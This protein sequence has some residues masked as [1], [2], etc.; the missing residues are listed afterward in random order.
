MLLYQSHSRRRLSNMN[1]RRGSE[2]RTDN[3]SRSRRRVH[4][5]SSCSSDRSEDGDSRS[6]SRTR[7]DRRFGTSSRNVQ[8]LSLS[9]S[10]I[11]LV[12]MSLQLPVTVE[13]QIIFTEIMYNPPLVEEPVDSGTLVQSGS[14]F[15]ELHNLD[16]V[17]S[18]LYP[19]TTPMYFMNFPYSLLLGRELH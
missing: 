6:E 9:L 17:D 4:L 12:V 14:E 1:G 5:S 10:M 18:V 19:P 11:T 3:C 7:S 15:L 2:G 8:G 13:G 16:T